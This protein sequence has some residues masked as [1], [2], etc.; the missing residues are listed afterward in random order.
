MFA[1]VV[2]CADFDHDVDHDSQCAGAGMCMEC[3]RAGVGV[4]VGGRVRRDVGHGSQCTGALS[5]RQCREAEGV[6]AVGV[7]QG[8]G[9]RLHRCALNTAV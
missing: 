3:V 2:G 9:H 8:M 4:C 5:T 1:C 7:W 6:C